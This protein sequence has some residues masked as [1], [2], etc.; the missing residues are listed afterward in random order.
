MTAVAIPAQREPVDLIKYEADFTVD[1]IEAMLGDDAIAREAFL[2]QVA[3]RPVPSP[4]CEDAIV[5]AARQ[6]R[7]L[8]RLGIAAMGRREAAVYVAG[9]LNEATEAEA[10]A[11]VAERI[12][13][14]DARR[15]RTIATAA[16]GVAE[17][18]R[19]ALTG[20][21]R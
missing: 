21:A 11:E 1:D 19:D 7:D 9:L 17:A 20:G 3:R 10:D 12:G 4:G 13:A 14:P 6:R 2:D 16:R 18:A 5:E 15:L 8:L